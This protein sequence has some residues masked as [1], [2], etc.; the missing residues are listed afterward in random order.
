MIKSLIASAIV[1]ASAFVAPAAEAAEGPAKCKHYD[2]Y[3]LCSQLVDSY[4]TRGND[5]W[6]LIITNNY[7]KHE[8]IVECQGKT[9]YQWW[10]P[11]ATATEQQF[12]GI[13]KGW[14]SI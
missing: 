12:Q 5:V 1:A 4:N 6:G 14:C 10:S 8:M 13:A 2:G 7:G 11:K 9:W 3:H